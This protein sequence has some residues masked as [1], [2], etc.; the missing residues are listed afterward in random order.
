MRIGEVAAQSEVNVQTV[1]LYERLG[2]LRKP[3]RRASGYREYAGDAVPAIR[4]I[5]Q[6]KGLGFTLNEIKSLLDMRKKGAH[7]IAEMRAVAEARL[8]AIDQKIRQLQAM[9]EAI[10]RGLSNCDCPEQFPA[11]V[12]VELFDR[13]DRK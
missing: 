11:C 10:Q 6:A 12:F 4:F 13:N 5:K 2:L 3:G 9:R 1:R 8:G 7:T